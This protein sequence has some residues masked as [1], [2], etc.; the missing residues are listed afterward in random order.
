MLKIVA[1]SN[2]VK[3]YN[4]GNLSAIQKKKVLHNFVYFNGKKILIIDNTGIYPNNS[5]P[6]IVL[7]TQSTKINVDRLL[8]ALKPKIVI[9][10]GSNYRIIQKQWKESCKKHKI[11]FHA[12]AEKGF[13]K[14][15]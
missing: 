8:I 6:D 4:L 10:D 14:L 11:P 7:L 2:I 1:Q 5:K 3:S 13:Y 15:N 12:T 9:A